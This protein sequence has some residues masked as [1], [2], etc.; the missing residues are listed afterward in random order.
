MMLGLSDDYSKAIVSGMWSMRSTV[1]TEEYAV[2]A[3]HP[4]ST[5]FSNHSSLPD[6]FTW[7]GMCLGG[8]TELTDIMYT[9]SNDGVN[10]RA[11]F[12]LMIMMH[13]YAGWES[14]DGGPHRNMRY[15]KYPRN[16]DGNRNMGFPQR[17][18][19]TGTMN[20]LFTDDDIPAP[21]LVGGSGISDM[22]ISNTTTSILPA[23]KSSLVNLVKP[24]EARL[25]DPLS[26]SALQLLGTLND[27]E[28]FT[29]LY[30]SNSPEM[31]S[32][33]KSRAW[34][35][36]KIAEMTSFNEN[37]AENILQFNG[38]TTFVMKLKEEGLDG[39]DSPVTDEALANSQVR[40]DVTRSIINSYLEKLRKF[41]SL[42]KY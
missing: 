16:C 31:G 11:M 27:R 21:E 18:I 17:E 6:Y 23:I 40:P 8:Q 19:L 14:I 41:K 26:I 22:A 12:E 39:V 4:H 32:T 33:V 20:A 7:R 2:G 5:H 42:D 35:E 10:K 9:L 34:Y 13:V 24:G 36:N 29:P 38:K 1:T 28:E 3:F 25:T 30:G 15:Y 37:F